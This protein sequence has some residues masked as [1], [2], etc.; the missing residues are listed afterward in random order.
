[1]T[2]PIPRFISAATIREFQK[3]ETRNER[4]ER[5][6]DFICQEIAEL[7]DRTSPADQPEIMLVTRDELHTIVCDAL[8]A[9]EKSR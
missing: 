5:I 1:M 7:P 6:A 9:S 4:H 8:A 2:A 3:E